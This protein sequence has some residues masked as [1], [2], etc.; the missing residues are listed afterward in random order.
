MEWQA[1]KIAPRILMPLETTKIKIDELYEKY[2]YSD[3]DQERT[4]ILE[5]VIDDL[6]DFYNVSKQSAKIRMI[7]LGYR[8]AAG[9]YNFENS[10]TPYFSNI[11][12]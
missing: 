10:L 2:G 12:P 8:E 7:D 11:S 5:R 1:N 3:N 9:A 6:A 4:E